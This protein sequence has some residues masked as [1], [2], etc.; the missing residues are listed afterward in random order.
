M[1]RSIKSF[2]SMKVNQIEP[3]LLQGLWG[4]RDNLVD[5]FKIFEPV[6]VMMMIA[7]SAKDQLGT[8]ASTGANYVAG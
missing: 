8:C 1:L 6:W 2:Q 7:A 4:I 3:H 5:S